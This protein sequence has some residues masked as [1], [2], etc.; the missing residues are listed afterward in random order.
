MNSIYD[1]DFRRL[2]VDLV[3]AV[4]RRPRLLAFL[5]A[6]VKPVQDLHATFLRARSAVYAELPITP[7]VCVLR[8]H[9]NERWDRLQRRIRILDGQ[10]GE[11][12]RLYTEAE[13]NPLFLPLTLEASRVD[14]L[15]EIPT[16]LRGY[17]RVIQAFLDRHKLPTKS[18]TIHYV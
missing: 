16:E 18:Y 8:Y 4:L 15:V 17:A 14:F 7:Q 9:L 11:G 13:G 5:D 1:I 12:P 10:D 6:L 2:T 3:P